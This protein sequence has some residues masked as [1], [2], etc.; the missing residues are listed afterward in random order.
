MRSPSWRSVIA[1]PSLALCATTGCIVGRSLATF[2]PARSPHGITLTITART[3][4]RLQGEL[5]ALSDS[6]LLVLVEERV[7]FLYADAI[8]RV[9]TA[10]GAEG[11]F[12]I[13][14]DLRNSPAAQ[15]LIPLSRYPA[16]VSTPALR[17][18]LTACSQEL[19][20]LVRAPRR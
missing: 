7:A 18:L 2:G 1:A 16:G 8:D 17:Q 12:V 20:E 6:G 3:G 13:G 15:R 9:R 11:F 4:L 5:L 14:G 10:A 19:P